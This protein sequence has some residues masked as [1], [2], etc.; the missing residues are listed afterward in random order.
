MSMHHTEEME[1]PEKDPFRTNMSEFSWTLECIF[2]VIA[3]I[4]L[5]ECVNALLCVNQW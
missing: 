1:N 5:D 2:I 4:V 3:N